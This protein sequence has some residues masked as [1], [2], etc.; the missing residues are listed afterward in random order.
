MRSFG[1]YKQKQIDTSSTSTITGVVCF[2]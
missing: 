1:T 2:Q